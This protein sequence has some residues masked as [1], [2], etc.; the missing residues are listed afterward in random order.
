MGGDQEDA[1]G[2]P[3]RGGVNGPAYS[4]AL[5]EARKEL[6]GGV[7]TIM[8]SLAGVEFRPAAGGQDQ[9]HFRVPFVDLLLEVSHPE[10]VVRY[11][12][13]EMDVDVT[14][15]VL[16][17]LARS[18]GPLALDDPVRYMGLQGASAFAAA[19]RA[20]VEQPLIE[21]FGEDPAAFD[22]AAAKIGGQARGPLW[23]IPF[24]PHLPLSLRL[25][26]AD[27]AFPADCVIL[28]PKRAG[29]IYLV[30]DL[31][32]AGQLLAGRLANAADEPEGT[33]NAEAGQAPDPAHPWDLPGLLAWARTK[34]GA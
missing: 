7:P 21:R 11:R 24:L 23:Q 26:E 12:G 30:E 4:R 10:G 1:L 31:A 15:V 29:F 17:Y 6:L 27:G 13:A 28:F 34:E 20:R 2:Q 16:H 18:V 33:E 14:V 8:A 5:E 25:G 3:R 9:G 32:V 22:R 19:F